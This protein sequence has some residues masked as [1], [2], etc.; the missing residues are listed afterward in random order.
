VNREFMRYRPLPDTE[1][2]TA[3]RAVLREPMLTADD[4]ACALRASAPPRPVDR[5]AEQTAAVRRQ[6]ADPAAVKAL[7]ALQ[8]NDRRPDPAVQATVEL[9]FRGR[10]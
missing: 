5:Q 8:F 9:Q 4:I 10:R 7:V 2:E 6:L 1:Y 3:L